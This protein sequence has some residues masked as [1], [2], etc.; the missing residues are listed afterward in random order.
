MEFHDGKAQPRRL[1][2]SVPGGPFNFAPPGHPHHL[3]RVLPLLLLSPCRRVLLLL[4]G[5]HG[6]IKVRH[7]KEEKFV[8]RGRPVDLGQTRG[9]DGRQGRAGGGVKMKGLVGKLRRALEVFTPG[10][11]FLRRDVEV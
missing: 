1:Q 3:H 11:L 10:Y 5:L 9:N 7:K 4:P 8:K 2:H 6:N